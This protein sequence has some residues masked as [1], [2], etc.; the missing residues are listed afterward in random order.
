MHVKNLMYIY[1]VICVY[2]DENPESLL[3]LYIHP[4]PP[5]VIFSK[6]FP[7]LDVKARGPLLARFSEKRPSSLSFVI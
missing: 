5:A 3:D 1:A 7:R 4:I 2:H 6:L